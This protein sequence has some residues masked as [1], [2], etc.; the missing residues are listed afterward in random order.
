MLFKA[1]FLAHAPDADPK[2][3]HCLRETSLHK[4]FVVY[5]KKQ[6]QAVE[7][8]QKISA[9]KGLHSIPLCPGFTNRNVADTHAAVGDKVAV[10]VA[11]TDG[12]DSRKVQRVI[13]EIG[14]FKP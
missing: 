14:W 12:P 6:T 1:S 9:E 5:V 13:K 3:P 7:I 10:E 8:L 11:R 2:K 4:L